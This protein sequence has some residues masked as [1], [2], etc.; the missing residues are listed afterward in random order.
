MGISL[1]NNV[2]HIIVGD[3]HNLVELNAS[4]AI[5]ALLVI[6]LVGFTIRKLRR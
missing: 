6:A 1:K 3:Y 5:L 4:I 2:G